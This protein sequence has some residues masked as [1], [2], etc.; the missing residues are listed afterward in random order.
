[1]RGTAL[2]A[3]PLLLI[4]LVANASRARPTCAWSSTS[5]IALVLVLSIQSFSGNSGIVSFGHVAFM[6]VGAYTAALLTIPPAIK[7]FILP[8]LPAVDRA[9]RTS[10]SCRRC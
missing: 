4:A 8:D 9:T 3:V 10:A 2:L 1:M 6:G 5:S 7:E